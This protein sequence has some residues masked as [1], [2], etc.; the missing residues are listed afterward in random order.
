MTRHRPMRADDAAAVASLTTELGYAVD[1]DEMA[2]R[3][4]PLLGRDDHLLLVATDPQDRPIGWMH[5]VRY[6]TLE[7]S[8][9]A[10]I[11]GIIVDE[12][13]RSSGI[14]RGLVEAGEAWARAAGVPSMLVRSRSTRTRAHRFYERIGYVETK[15]SHVFEKPLV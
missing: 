15:R 6:A 7:T 14:G 2:A 10:V 13:A 3:I 4:V 9:R 5:V 11:A 12:S 8:E 1:P